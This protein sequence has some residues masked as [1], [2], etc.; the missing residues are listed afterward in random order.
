MV[1][2][3]NIK[4]FFEGRN[5]S[6]DWRGPII[7]KWVESRNMNQSMQII[8]RKIGILLSQNARKK[9]KQW[10]L[11][12]DRD[13]NTIT[14]ERYIIDYLKGINKNI[15]DNIFDSQNVGTDAELIYNNRRIGI[16]ITTLNGFVADWIFIERL[17]IYLQE[18]NFCPGWSLEIS[19][20]YGRLKREMDRHQIY[21]Y[22]E[23]V[24]ECLIKGD[25]KQMKQLEVDAVNTKRRT[26]CI[27]WSYSKADNFPIM[28]YLTEGL[29][30]KLKE[31]NKQLSKHKENLVFVGV[32]HAGPTNRANPGIF[33]EM[34]G[35]GI[36]YSPQINA[37]REFLKN[38]LPVEIIGVCYFHY[39]LDRENPFYPLTTFWRRS[40]RKLPINL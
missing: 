11:S 14:S 6:N 29:I 19:Y 24:G 34:G 36:S 1:T 22:I 28:N 32:N 9:L 17:P 20:D 35:K 3:N 16:E 12:D 10:L 21:E 33:K 8:D 39:S 25:L 18:H 15:N 2:F 27:A 30:Q 5:T 4:K 38:E 26:G 7:L 40:N 23:K 31:K 37:I 13:F